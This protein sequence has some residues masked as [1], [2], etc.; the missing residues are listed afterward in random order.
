MIHVLLPV[1][2]KKHNGYVYSSQYRKND[3]ANFYRTLTF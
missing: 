1:L 2:L 3:Y